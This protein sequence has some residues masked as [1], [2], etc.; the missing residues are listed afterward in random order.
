MT[1]TAHYRPGSFYLGSPRQSLLAHG[2]AQVLSSSDATALADQL[3]GSGRFVVGGL[4]FDNTA[5]AHLIVPESVR[6][7]G[8]GR[9][10][11]AEPGTIERSVVSDFE[12]QTVPEPAAHANTVRAAIKRL[13][14]GELDKVV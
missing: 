14:A 3:A 12:L 8:A 9:G 10:T 7:S 4:P 1:L 13:A 5:A 2:T 11:D 6:S